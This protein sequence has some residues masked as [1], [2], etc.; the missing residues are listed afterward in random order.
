MLNR[1]EYVWIL[2]ALLSVV[3]IVIALSAE[4]YKSFHRYTPPAEQAEQ[5]SLTV[6]GDIEIHMGTYIF[7]CRKVTI[8]E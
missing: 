4:A 3:T 5:Q 1:G 8:H 7:K 6:S 2:I